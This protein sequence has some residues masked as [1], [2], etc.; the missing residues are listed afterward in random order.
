MTDV[1]KKIK[2]K[3]VKLGK[4]WGNVVAI[5][6][7]NLEVEEGEFITLLGP[8]GC[9]KTTTLRSIAGLEEPTEGYIYIDGK[10]VF[11][12]KDEVVVPPSKR[13]VGLI[14]QSYA[15]W[16]HMTVFEN[17][18]FGLK[19]KKLPKSQ[20]ERMVMQVLQDVRLNG[21]EN[22]YPQELSGGQQQRVA[23]ARMIINRPEIFLMDEPLSNLDARLRLEMRTELKELHQKAGATTVYVTHDQVE[24]M[25]MSTKVCIMKDGVIHQVGDPEEVYRKPADLFVAE[26]ISN[27][28]MNFFEGKVMRNNG[29]AIV[30]AGGFELKVD[31][32]L[33]GSR[34]TVT[35]AIRPEDFIISDDGVAYNVDTQLPAGSSK[36]VMASNEK[37]RIALL[38]E[39][40][41]KIDPG[42]RLRLK[43]KDELFNLFDK[44]S[45][46]RIF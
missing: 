34:E 12:R 41:F 19:M 45:G 20:I 8:S 15:L 22:R 42:A 46:K 7:M 10:L 36:I 17:I 9:G 28:K 30:H 1:D 44:V 40:S 38:F 24:A 3:I 39:G 35:V 13:K 14:F 43:V 25:T 23:I 16:P 29:I 27:P 32:E 2:I 21:L 31:S 33:I 5:D 26:F 18:A 6:D 4:R 11:S 37:D